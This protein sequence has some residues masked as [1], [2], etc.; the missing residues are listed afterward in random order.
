MDAMTDR[1]QDTSDRE[2]LT[3]R[4]VSAPR[5]VV[6]EAWSKP[7]HL[8]KWWG[9]R[10]FTTT[11][12][13]HDFRA[14][15]HWKLTMH[16][17]DGKDYP[18]H[19][20]YEEI[21]WPA[22]IVHRHEGGTDVK[23]R[24]TFFVTFEEEGAQKTR[25]TIRMVFRTA[26]ERDATAARYGA[27]EG[28]KETLARLDET[29]AAMVARDV[30]A[31][32]PAPLR[33]ER[34]LAAPRRLVFEAWTKAEHL[35]KWLPPH[36]FT[37]ARCESDARAGGKLTHA[38]RG[39]D[40]NEYPFE[41]VYREVDAPSRV[42]WSGIIHGDVEVVTTATFEEVDGGKR[43]KVT[44]VQTY[45]RESPAVRGAPIGWGQSLEKLG[46]LLASLA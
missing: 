36:H 34:V 18:N 20:V 10:G 6:F 22:R 9:P 12:H 40:G 30:A 15:G 19:H 3:T 17:P 11:T 37:M 29:V 32:R 27:I 42:V 24:S 31:A 5:E 41:G 13:S 33:L 25:V 2:I 4:V 44:V 38:F 28:A 26:A 1:T 7:E 43:T 16:G 23:V 39:P 8:A 14:G 46:E 45:S 35:S 21:V